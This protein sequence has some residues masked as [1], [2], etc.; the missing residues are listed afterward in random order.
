MLAVWRGGFGALA[1]T[2]DAHKREIHTPS[3]PRWRRQQSFCKD[4]LASDEW[5]IPCNLWIHVVDVVNIHSTFNAFSSQ[6]FSGVDTR[7]ETSLC[8]LIHKGIKLEVDD[9]T[10]L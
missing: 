2:C 9:V 10:R 6:L 7:D 3:N 8:V 1:F 4:D 5:L